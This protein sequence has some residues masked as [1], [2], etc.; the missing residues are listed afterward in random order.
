MKTVMQVHQEIIE[1]VMTEKVKGDI[2][3]E[4]RGY[5]YTEYSEINKL[6]VTFNISFRK[7]DKDHY[8]VTD[9]RVFKY[10]NESFERTGTTKYKMFWYREEANQMGI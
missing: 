9:N 6:T 8:E 5:S 4:G 7:V 10:D 2:T 3:I 1:R